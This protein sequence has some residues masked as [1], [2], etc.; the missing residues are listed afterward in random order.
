MSDPEPFPA[1]P[2]RPHSW[3]EKIDLLTN[4]APV[5]PTRLAMAG[6]AVVAVVVV[7]VLLFRQPATSAPELDLP[8]ASEA[9]ATSSTTA[10]A[11]EVVVHAAGAVRQPGLYRLA[12]GARVADV[13]EAA[14][15]PV[16]GADLDRLNLA[17]PVVD[18]ERIYVPAVGEVLA[19]ENAPPGEGA[20]GATLVDLNTASAEQLET[21]PGVGPATAAA[22]IEERERRGRFGSVEELLDVRGIGEAK[23]EELRPL[24]RV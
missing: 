24:V 11:T 7:A 16:E 6:A 18:G 22:I 14:G 12:G 10:V 4:G 13:V 17:A 1:G 2:E 23:L 21:L 9:P 3:Q 15:G 20:E 19:P 5:S 8:L